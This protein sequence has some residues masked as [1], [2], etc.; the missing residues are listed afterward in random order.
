MNSQ[1]K[2]K[3]IKDLLLEDMSKNVQM[4]QEKLKVAKK[5]QKRLKKQLK[6]EKKAQRRLTQELNEKL[7]RATIENKML[8]NSR[9]GKLKKQMLSADELSLIFRK[10]AEEIEE[11]KEQRRSS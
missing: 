2:F 5:E 9:L 8:L 6:K 1:D 4:L 10:I 3:K 7:K 11:K